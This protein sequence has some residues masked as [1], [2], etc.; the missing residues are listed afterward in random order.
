MPEK[1]LGYK[2]AAQVVGVSEM[3][4]RRWVSSRYNKIP[5]HKLGTSGKAPVRFFSSELE[6][7]IKA[8]DEAGN[9]KK[10]IFKKLTK[11]E[12]DEIL[13]DG[14]PLAREFSDDDMEKWEKFD[15]SKE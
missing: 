4:L 15:E 2:E 8:H 9:V 5:A 13:K 7:W 12:Y 3:T 14:S 10:P 11:Q 6:A 1:T